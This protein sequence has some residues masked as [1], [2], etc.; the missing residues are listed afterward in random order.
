MK[1]SGILKYKSSLR[2]FHNSKLSLISESF[3]HKRADAYLEDVTEYFEI[4]GDNIKLHGY[5]VLYAVRLA[6]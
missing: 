5:D 3:F 4:V 2:Y 6:Y 1:L